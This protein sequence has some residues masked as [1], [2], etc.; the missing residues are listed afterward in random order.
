MAQILFFDSGSR[1]FLML[2]FAFL[3][4]TVLIWRPMLRLRLS[5]QKETPTNSDCFKLG[6]AEATWASKITQQTEPQC[7][8]DVHQITFIKSQTVAWYTFPQYIKSP[9]VVLVRFSA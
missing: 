6:P 5:S 1:V 3:L 4:D 9:L 7:F 2:K 8:N